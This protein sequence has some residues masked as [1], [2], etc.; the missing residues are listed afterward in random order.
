MDQKKAEAAVQGELFKRRR[1]EIP[2]AERVLTLQEKLYQKAKQER[3]YKFYV[4]YDKM[5]IPYMLREAWKKV[6]SNGGSPGV[7]GLSIAEIE[8]QGI[9]E[10]LKELGEELRKQTYRPQAVK[11]VMIPKANGGERPLGIPTVRDR[12]TCEC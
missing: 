3:D 2:D 1:G 5:F 12:L 6:K 10:Y 11:R 9:E 4:L 7:D 8:Q